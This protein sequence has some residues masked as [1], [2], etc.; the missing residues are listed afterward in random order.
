[1][2]DQ[3]WTYGCW[4]CNIE[5][6]GYPCEDDAEWEA[7]DHAEMREGHHPTYVRRT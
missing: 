2:Q 6:S 5:E 3:D 7:A 4:K 1:M